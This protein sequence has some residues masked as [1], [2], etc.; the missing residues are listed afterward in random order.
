MLN[1]L[2]AGVSEGGGTSQSLA[3]EQHIGRWYWNKQIS[4]GG[5]TGTTNSHADAWFVGVTPKLVVGAW[6]GGEY[7]QIHFRT[8]A[9]GQGSRTALPICGVFLN[10]VL[11]NPVLAQ[12]YLGNFEK[13]EGVEETSLNDYS[14]EDTTGIIDTLTFEMDDAEFDD[15][16][17]DLDPLRT[18][19]E[20]AP[21]QTFSD[22]NVE[23]D[24]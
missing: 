8:G 15:I 2:E 16:M 20:E 17:D 4:A 14:Y 24:A 9:L 13:P 19:N 7:P 21:E 23:I 12:K 3:S 22:P 11:S 1:L 18:T 5:K 6:V 10:K